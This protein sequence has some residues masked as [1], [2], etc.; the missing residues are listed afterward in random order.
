MVKS[1]VHGGVL[2]DRKGVNVPDVLVPIPALAAKDRRDLD[3]RW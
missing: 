3:F 2:S 1:V